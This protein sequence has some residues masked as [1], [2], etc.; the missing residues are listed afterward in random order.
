MLQPE[1]KAGDA[2]TNYAIGVNLVVTFSNP[3]QWP[4]DRTQLPPDSHSVQLFVTRIGNYGEMSRRGVQQLR[5]SE[6]NFGDPSPEVYL[7]WGRGDLSQNLVG[8]W[9]I[10][11]MWAGYQPP[12]P[13]QMGAA[14]DWSWG[15]YGGPAESNG[16][17]DIRFRVRLLSPTKMEI[18]FGS[19]FE[20][21]T[22]CARLM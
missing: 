21:A 17:Q 3:T 1:P 10:P 19:G 7:L 9:H 13:G 12:E 2:Q 16:L 5:Y 4:T 14:A 18:G 8:D 15:K 20:S 11:Y 22:A 6:L